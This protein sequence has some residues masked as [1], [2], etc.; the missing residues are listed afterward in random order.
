MERDKIYTG[1]RREPDGGKLLSA[2]N[3][4]DV[5]RQQARRLPST[6]PT[7]PTPNFIVSPTVAN[8]RLPST[9]PTSAVNAPDKIYTDVYWEPDSGKLLS[10][11]NEPD[12]CRQRARRLLS[13]GPTSAVNGPDVCHQRTRQTKFKQIMQCLLLTGPT[14]AIDSLVVCCQGARHQPPTC[15]MSAINWLKICYRST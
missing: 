8:C 6:G 4:P 9:G 3:G 2:V 13:T 14:S 11:V 7:K 15:T 1:V 10:A 5:C 12:V